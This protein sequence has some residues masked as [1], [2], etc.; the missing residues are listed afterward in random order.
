MPLRR[1][2]LQRLTCSHLTKIADRVSPGRLCEWPRKPAKAVR[3]TIDSSNLIVRNGLYAKARA[4]GRSRSTR[5]ATSGR[6]RAAALVVDSLA[7][8]RKD[9]QSAGGL[10]RQAGFR[11]SV[12]LS[13]EAAVA[14]IIEVTSGESGSSPIASIFEGS[15][16]DG[17]SV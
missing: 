10:L 7:L 1:Q 13:S 9:H 4:T 11:R 14:E 12:E 15:A 2:D 17:H 3:P 6:R 5:P 16:P 8:F